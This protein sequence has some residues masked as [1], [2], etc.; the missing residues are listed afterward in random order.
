[1]THTRY[2]FVKA[3]WHSDIVNRALDGFLEIIPARDVDVFDVPG[4][5]ELPLMSRDLAATES[6]PPWLPPPSS[7]MAASTVTISWP[8]PSSMA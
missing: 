8:K 7:S 6:T 5:F 3:N 4:A 1:M 2:A